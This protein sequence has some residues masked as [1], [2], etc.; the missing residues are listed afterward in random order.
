MKDYTIQQP[1][2][3]VEPTDRHS[4]VF[5]CRKNLRQWEENENNINREELKNVEQ[6]NYSTIKN[7]DIPIRQ[8]P[9]HRQ[10]KVS[11]LVKLYF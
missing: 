1:M 5:Q 8:P 6:F 9:I 7:F 4:E 3:E 2:Y 11:I 10:R